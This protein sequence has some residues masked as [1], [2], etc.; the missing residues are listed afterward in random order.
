MQLVRNSLNDL[1]HNTD[2]AGISL[3]KSIDSYLT[4]FR[5]LEPQIHAFVPEARLEQRLKLEQERLLASLAGTAGRPALWGI[6]V[7]I[8]DLIHAESLPTQAGSRLPAEALAGGEASIVT[9]LRELGAVIAGKTVT[10]EFAYHGP[11][12]TLNPHHSEHTPGG[13]SAGSAAAVAA[14]L[15]PLALGTQTLRSVLAPAS[16][17]GVVGFKPS[18]DRVPLDG[19]IKLSPSFDTIGLFTQD[20]SGM[21]TAA[22]LLIP[23]WNARQVSRKPVLGI[24]GGVY[25][26]L[27][28]DEV[29]AVFTA[30]IKSL[31]QFGYQVKHVQMPWEDELIYG[32]AMLRFIQ[33]EMAREHAERFGAYEP[34]YGASVRE[35]ILSG[36]A[37]PE[38]ELA[39]CRQLQLELRARL[40]NLM[41]QEGIDLWVS[42][43][44]GGTAPRLEAN[45][46]GWSGMTAVWGFAGCPALS[47]PAA[48][49]GGLPLGFQCVGSYG[50]DE[51]LLAR[52]RQVVLELCPDKI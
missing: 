36:E 12:A 33:G 30:Q 20:L 22:E 37:I 42:P 39:D 34:Y 43:A 48:S 40:E 46:T 15:C 4:R 16:F 11:I 31:E 45:N 19:V 35:A 13:S 7:G 17:C 29:K 18:Y 14:G 47:I 49:I 44:Q 26:E 6:P 25:M 51:W 24:P 10:E 27:M 1:I 41:N 2:E 32:N 28:S 9:R 21:E 8:K 3:R 50:E 5:E 52:A 38:E 23:E